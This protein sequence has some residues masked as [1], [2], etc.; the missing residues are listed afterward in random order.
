MDIQLEVCQAF[1]LSVFSTVSFLTLNI[2]TFCA[3]HV[4]LNDGVKSF[5]SREDGGREGESPGTAVPK[6]HGILAGLNGS[7]QRPLLPRL[8]PQEWSPCSI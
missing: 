8:R 3:K 4:V 5:P 7:E 6:Q 2:V 1:S